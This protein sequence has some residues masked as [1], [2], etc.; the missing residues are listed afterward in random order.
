[1]VLRIEGNNRFH[2]AGILAEVSSCRSLMVDAGA[3]LCWIT[4][5]VM[6]FGG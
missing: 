6:T 5:F 4:A 1:M 2:R 3:E